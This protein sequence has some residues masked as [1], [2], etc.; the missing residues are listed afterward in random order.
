DIKGP[1]ILNGGAAMAPLNQ[2]VI[3]DQNASAAHSY[4]LRTDNILAR[5]GGTVIAY[6]NVG[7]LSLFT[8]NFADS[9]AVLGTSADTVAHLDL[10]GG[11]DWVTL[12][13]AA[14]SL[15][16]FFSTLGVDG[17]SGIDTIV[18]NDQGDANANAYSVTATDVMRNGH[19]L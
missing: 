8:S 15:D 6:S 16:G 14:I 12:G 5:S 2:L 3:L 17:G 1:L 9:V 4:T 19:G 13:T 11:N 7:D 10:G 18:L